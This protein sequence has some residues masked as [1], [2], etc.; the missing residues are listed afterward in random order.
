LA[1]QPVESLHPV[2]DEGDAL[3]LARRENETLYRVIKTVS[4]SLDLDRVLGGIVDIATDAT[5]CHA[6][7]IYFLE[8][9]RLVLRAASKRYSRFVG[10]LGLGVD[11]GL[12]GWVARTKTP[13]FIPENAMDDRRMKYLP[14]L[15]EERF[16]SMVAVPI[17]AKS[18]DVIGV[19]VLHTAA[20]REFE[21]DILNFLIHTASLVAGAIENAQLYEETRRRVQ[22]LTT[23]TGLSQALAT[24]TVREDLYDAVTR[25]ARELLEADACQIYRLDV[26]ADELALV[27][28]DPVGAPAP[29]PRPGG[30]GLVLE[31]MRRANGR[32]RVARGRVARELWPD[33]DEN[34]L[35]V[36]PLVAGDEQLGILCCLAH[37]RQFAVEDAELLGAVADQTAVGLKKAELI[38]RLTAENIVKD[39]FD[40]L[41]AGSVEAA[42][43]KASEADCDLSRPHLFLHV[44]SAPRTPGSTPAWPDLVARLEAKLRRLNLRAF[45][46][47]RHDRVRALATLPGEPGPSVEELRSACEP[48]VRDEGLVV[49]LSDV[50]RG[51]AS[52]R[53]R[54]R[55]AG[56]AA[57][58]GRSLAVEGGAV[59][60]E[61]LG[62]YRYLVHLE[63][64]D[65]PRDRY[66]Q[67]VGELIAY[68]KRRG[69]RLVETLEQY[70]ADRGSV[71]ASARTL[72][73]HPNTVRQRLERIERVA[74]LN[75]DREDLLSLELALKLV[76]L[77][78]LRAGEE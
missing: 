27:G 71:T 39:M 37:D 2:V 30:A 55:E 45:F 16:Q 38:E 22:A 8:G 17:L 24:V 14:E 44:E 77:H 62:A 10:E 29:S 70:L 3:R 41:A 67:S 74:D 50:D 9:E 76:R 61:Q 21:E 60:Y 68:D 59:S 23:L 69:A 34:A 36:A 49:G 12:A 43:A 46:D 48:L 20:P 15:E 4:S 7:F 35:L 56:D 52:A 40:A 1:V 58:I 31:L 75:L 42:E 72:Y 13:E 19:A 57:R 6:C 78:E 33:V 66:R 64:D 47:T 51:A 65:A 26:E 25:G 54:M 32:G 28:S 63:L 18:G 73:V 53:R 5:G 11:E